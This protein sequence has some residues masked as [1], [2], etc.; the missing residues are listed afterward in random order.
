MNSRRRTGKYSRAPL[1]WGLAMFL[2]CQTAF[3][4]ALDCWYPELYDA[5][6]ARRLATLRTRQAEAPE[7]PLFLV[8]GSSRTA[9]AFRPEILPPLP[10]RSG[11]PVLPFNF[12]HMGAGPL[13]NLV[14]LRRLL[15]DGVCPT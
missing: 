8:L 6:Y 14:E 15:A 4:A 9:L 13:L 10:T 11:P 2:A 1:L 3:A 7:R 12:S 5:E